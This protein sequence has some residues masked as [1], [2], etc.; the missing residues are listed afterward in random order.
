M[1]Q[2]SQI[3]RRTS[4]QSNAAQPHHN[5]WVSANAGTGKT[6]VLVDRIARL[7]LDG[8][9]PQKILCLTFTKTG[10]AEMS[11]RIS[12]LLGS[13]AMMDDVTLQ[14]EL[15]GLTGRDTD[16]DL[17]ATARRLFAQVLDVP[18][19]LK[20]RTIHS[21]CESLIGRFPIEAKIAPHFS[22]IEDRTSVEL[23]NN[24]REHILEHTINDPKG[25][26]APALNL[27]AELLNEDDFTGLMKNLVSKRARFYDVLKAYEKLGGR[28]S[29]IMQ[30]VGLEDEDTDQAMIIKRILSGPGYN[31]PGLR[32]AAD[33]LL[34]GAKTSV[35]KGKKLTAFLA[36]SMEDKILNYQTQYVPL[37][38]TQ[39]KQP[40]KKLITKGAEQA[41]ETL[42][43]EQSRVVEAL[44]KIRARITADATLALFTVGQSMIEGYEHLKKNHAYMDYDDL[45][46]TA[47]TLLNTHS[48]ISWVHFK[49]DGGIDH[50]LVDESQDTSAAQW[51]VVK[52]LAFDFY[53]GQGRH[54]DQDDKPRTIFAVGDE[55]QSIYSFQGADP[56]EFDRM[57]DYFSARVREADQDF[58]DV[59]LNVSFRTVSAI[60]KIVDRVF[61][62]PDA[63]DG[64]SFSGQSVA[65][66]TSRKGEAGL[67]ELWPTFKTDKEQ[68]DSPWDAPLDYQNS[69]SAE[70]QLADKIA[71]TVQGWLRNKEMLSAENRPIRAGDI[72]ILVRRRAKFAETMITSL[73]KHGIDVAGADRMTLTN[74][75]AVMDLLAVGRFALMPEDNLSLAEVLKSPLIGLNDDALFNLAHKRK[76]TL[77]AELCARK[78]ERSEYKTAQTKLYDFLARADFTPPY[79]FFAHL[80]QNG[81]RKALVQ[82]LGLDAQDPI[83][84]FLS[85]A[86]EYERSHTPSLQGFLHWVSAGGTEI[87]RDM[88]TSGNEVR[89]MTVHG[90]KGLEAPIVFLTDTCKPPDSRSDSPLQWGKD[91]P[92]LLWAPYTDARCQAFAA[93][94]DLARLESEREYRRLLY[95]AMTRARDRLYVTGF[96][97]S[98]G[99]KDG[100]W[101]NMV[102]A[103]MDDFGTEISGSDDVSIL[104]Y[105]TLQEIP[106]KNT[107]QNKTLGTPLAL[108]AWIQDKPPAEQSPSRPLSP[109]APTNDAPPAFGP[110]TDDQTDRFK[111]GLIIHKLLEILP[112]LPFEKRE[113]AARTWLTRPGH[114]LRPQQQSE[115]LRETMAVLN[116]PE[117]SQLFNLESMAEVA[118]SGILG[119]RVVSARLDRLSIKDNIVTVVDYKTNRPAPV[120]VD[121][122][123]EAYLQQMATYRALLSKI[124]KNHHIRCVLL[125]TDGPHAMVLDDALLKT[126]T[127]GTGSP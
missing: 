36:L 103:A 43:T 1:S 115:I 29:A 100:C 13:W 88:E 6:R 127:L 38:L 75:I 28:Q 108:P 121:K 120:D 21:F 87:K 51:D 109:S 12:T 46:Q 91:Q 102:A 32:A 85:L 19:G 5:V 53:S 83:D 14:A 90:A 98:Q 123:P 39:A 76:G 8:A 15:H 119:D 11:D 56:F 78:N 125:W 64:L 27:M 50:I 41:E 47:R 63:A 79:E 24:T 74:Q 71:G 96:E 26:L 80:L 94:L 61:A 16:Q 60:I 65:H 68:E 89:V 72:L 113:S 101:Y 126:Y 3:L 30:L 34:K 67:V 92:T 40:L 57:K 97:D 20:I 82:R 33:E 93:T 117:L 42:C 49:L 54:E 105:E 31:E 22:V 59:T 18:G 55:K 107:Q 114:N 9:E 99:R 104:R 45:I 25:D 7:L 17:I 37:F 111:R 124:Y 70:R 73:K 4:A 48:G 69:K 110:F 77:W 44:E 122:V 106:F 112:G 116:N 62:K 81:G 2:P 35:E 66:D 86:L 23:L 84:E 52:S 118:I 95:V 10:A 58:R